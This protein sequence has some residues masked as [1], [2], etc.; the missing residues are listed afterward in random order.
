MHK[1]KKSGHG[2]LLIVSVNIPRGKERAMQKLFFIWKE[3]ATGPAQA[4][5]YMQ[6][7]SL[8]LITRW[9]QF[10]HYISTWLSHLLMKNHGMAL[11]LNWREYIVRSE[12]HIRVA[13]E[14]TVTCSF[15]SFLLY[16]SEFYHWNEKSLKQKLREINAWL[17]ERKLVQEQW[18]RGWVS[19][20]AEPD[21][22]SVAGWRDVGK[23]W[24]LKV[25]CWDFFPHFTFLVKD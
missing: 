20:E 18:N 2:G 6:P 8:C 11:F 19:P 13:R 10:V 12:I 17:I 16:N 22:P 15:W 21:F 9:R 1:Q 14:V 23:I 24:T 4:F 5:I 3:F 7:T 25:A